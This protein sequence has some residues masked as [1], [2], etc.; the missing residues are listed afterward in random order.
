VGRVHVLVRVRGQLD[1]GDLW[2]YAGRASVVGEESLVTLE[3]DDSRELVGALVALT[4]RGL[5]IVRV[6]TVERESGG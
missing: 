5:Q 2:P 3:V 6:D 1:D 4:Q